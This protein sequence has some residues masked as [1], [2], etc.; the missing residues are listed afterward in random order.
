M[1]P[2]QTVNQF[3][4]APF[5]K[6]GT[7]GSD[8]FSSTLPFYNKATVLVNKLRQSNFSFLIFLSPQTKSTGLK[9]VDAA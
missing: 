7:V 5:H 1:A 6:P 9:C 2:E 4:I 3:A 8:S